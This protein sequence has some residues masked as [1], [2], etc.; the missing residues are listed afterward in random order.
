MGL[1]WLFLG[2][3]YCAKSIKAIGG[4]LIFLLRTVDLALGV[5][6][7]VVAQ[8][9]ME[10][11]NQ[12][13]SRSAMRARSKSAYDRA[14]QAIYRLAVRTRAAGRRT[15]KIL[16]LAFARFRIRLLNHYYRIKSWVLRSFTWLVVG[17]IGLILMAIFA[18]DP[19]IKVATADLMTDQRI[20]SLR[21]ALLSVGSQL[22][23]ISALV[24]ALVT[25]ALQANLERMPYT[26][27]ARL[28][29]DR[30]LLFYFGG[31]FVL[32]I[33]VACL[34]LVINSANA[35]TVALVALWALIVTITMI[36]L[37]FKRALTLVSPAYQLSRIVGDVRKGFDAWDRRAKLYQPLLAS[38]SPIGE[39]DAERLAFFAI[40]GNWTAEAQQAI[41]HASAYVRHYANAGDFEVSGSAVNCLVHINDLYVKVKGKTF[42]GNQLLL[43]TGLST[44]AVVNATLE[45]LRQLAEHGIQSNNETLAEQA[46]TGLAALVP[47]Y[48]KIDYGRM[49][50]GKTHANLAAGYLNGAVKAAIPKNMADVVMHGTRLLG[51]SGQQFLAAR[52]PTEMTGVVD[53]LMFL[54]MAGAVRENFRPVTQEAM[55]QM[56][57]LTLMLMQSEGHD[58]KFAAGS[59][60]KAVKQISTVF[61][62]VP[63]NQPMSIHDAYLGPYLSTRLP[64]ALTELANR[65]INAE[66]GNAA[67][68]RIVRNVE[69]WANDAPLFYKDLFIASLNAKSLLAVGISHSVV[70]VTRVLIGLADADVTTDHTKEELLRHADWL[71]CA[72]SWVPD[73][74]EAVQFAE[75]CSLTSSLSD[76][77]LEVANSEHDSIRETA[78]DLVL[79]WAFKSARRGSRLHSPAKCIATIA[80]MLTIQNLQTVPDRIRTSVARRAA[81]L[82]QDQRQEIQRHVQLD[83]INRR[84]E[85]FG[86]DRLG[87][88]LAQVDRP[89][90]LALTRQIL[91]EI[92]PAHQGQQPLQDG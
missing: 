65:I 71:I 26:L 76:F 31:T 88:V 21:S 73:T 22:I 1:H 60:L 19:W 82:T 55:Q 23:G 59:I 67:A 91:D 8:A 33:V 63:D 15:V 70:Q 58:I 81:E 39:H 69:S 10:L 85:R 84:P 11:A 20:E 41:H 86:I 62:Q 14:R 47:V 12:I 50:P 53:D 3:G 92:V 78:V 51:A 52:A 54:G 6:F 74:D 27:F 66:P 90:F 37:S 40:H 24:F 13:P 34:S 35:A 44:D 68:E 5:A 7:D 79:G 4:A 57:N 43:D 18:F 28:T 49:M 32:S 89:R 48:C 16:R 30:L 64:S 87:Y 9:T 75:T 77:A 56:A 45:Q 29:S 42:F 61:M 46:M 17:I 25:F 80:A 2:G 36:L 83:Y 72:L 38:N